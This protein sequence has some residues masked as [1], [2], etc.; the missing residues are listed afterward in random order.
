MYQVFDNNKPADCFHHDV[1]GTWFKSKYE[2]FAEAFEY[3]TRWIN[4]RDVNG[5]VFL[6]PDVPWDYSGY[7]DM[8][9]IRTV[10]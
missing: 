1:H 3:A 7:G 4:L 10:E 6:K 2:T 9:E 8:I 5:C